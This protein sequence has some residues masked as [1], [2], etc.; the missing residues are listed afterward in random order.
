MHMILLR[1]WLGA[2]AINPDKDVRIITLPPR[3]M[4]GCMAAGYIDGFCAGEPWSS[5]AA[6]SGDGCTERGA[7]VGAGGRGTRAVK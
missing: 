5:V 6:V 3:Q 7:A 2:A 1:D 4:N